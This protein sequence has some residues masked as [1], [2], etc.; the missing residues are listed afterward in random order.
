LKFFE[1]FR[2]FRNF[3]KFLKFYGE[4]TSKTLKTQDG[5]ALACMHNVNIQYDGAGAS[6][7]YI[8]E[9]QLKDAGWYQCTAYN[10]AGSTATRGRVQLDMPQ[11]MPM[12]RPY[13]KLNLPQT[14]RLIEPQ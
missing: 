11:Q 9:T 4:I 1:I 10:E 5:T 6:R 14:G 12:I 2:N 7:V 3:S 8:A 13:F